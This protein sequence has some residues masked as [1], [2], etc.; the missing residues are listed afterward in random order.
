[1]TIDID[2]IVLDV[3][4][5]VSSWNAALNPVV[6]RMQRM[7]Y[8]FDVVNNNSGN[9]QLQINGIDLTASFSSGD[10]IFVKSENLVYNQIASV[11]SSSF[12]GGNTLINTSISY[13][14]AATTGFVNNHTK[15]SAYRV[16]VSVY[17]TSLVNQYPFVYSPNTAG[18]IVVDVMA[19][20]KS[21]LNPEIGFTP[22]TSNSYDDTN[23]YVKF[24]IGYKEVWVG[25][26]EP[27]V[28]D[29][30]NLFAV[31]AANQIPAA[32]G[33]NMFQFVTW[34][35]GSPLAKFLTD[36]FVMWR[37][38][39][40]HV[41]A[42]IN[43]GVD[44]MLV[45][46]SDQETASAERI[47]VF[48]INLILSDQSDDS[49]AMKIVD[50]ASPTTDLTEQVTVEMR[51]ACANPVMLIGRNRKGGFIQWMFDV[52]HEIEI[53]VQGER[54]AKRLTLSADVT[55]EQW[56]ALNDFIN[57]GEVYADS[58]DEL[59]SDVIR[60]KVRDGQQVY[61]I[62]QDGTLTGVIVLEN[63]QNTFAKKVKNRFTIEIEMPEML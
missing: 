54:K 14:S 49:Y 24:N 38:W 15:R 17:T 26:S 20:L 2:N 11:S 36:V 60:T 46:D 52:D 27:E 42:I 63:R 39:P 43:T 47:A 33:G 35:S 44:A 55:Q 23:A 4:G 34:P 6:Y 1:M 56:Y 31:L 53:N 50:Y 18:E 16:E 51:D 48:D 10:V 25:S 57:L 61:S 19:I 30:V 3:S 9:V 13:T 58:F 29:S 7:D 59:T 40:F 21:V 32:Y 5:N 12:S 8:I 41:S 37:G 45:I 22:N 28:V 62:A